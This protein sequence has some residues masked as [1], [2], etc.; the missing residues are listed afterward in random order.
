MQSG[1]AI[2]QKGMSDVQN[3]LKHQR[4]MS[5]IRKN[6]FKNKREFNTE[7][8]YWLYKNHINEWVKLSE[9]FELYLNTKER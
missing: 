6:Y 4:E 5:E 2:S 8:H 7:F 1:H 3:E 9:L